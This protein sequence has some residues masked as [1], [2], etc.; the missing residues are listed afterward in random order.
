[1]LL[2]RGSLVPRTGAPGPHFSPTPVRVWEN[3]LQKGGLRSAFVGRVWFTTGF[4][5]DLNADYVHDCVSWVVT[6]ISAIF[7]VSCI[8]VVA[9][10][11]PDV[12]HL[13]LNIVYDFPNGAQPRAEGCP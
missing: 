11:V 4:D 5:P 9:N 13:C 2:W 6:F 3:A 8:T 1:M 12:A 10:W 7:G